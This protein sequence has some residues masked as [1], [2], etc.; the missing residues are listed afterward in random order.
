[1]V[2]IAHVVPGHWYE[3]LFVRSALPFSVFFDADTFHLFCLLDGVG[4]LSCAE[5]MGLRVATPS[6]AVSVLRDEYLSG[7]DGWQV[8]FEP[9]PLS[10]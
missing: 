3:G 2:K 10:L 8:S 7:A 5:D 9:L 4:D 6:E 1:M